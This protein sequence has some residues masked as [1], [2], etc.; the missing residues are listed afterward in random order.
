MRVAVVHDWLVTYAGAERV[1]EQILAL[2]PEADVFTLVDFLP[3]DRRQ[4][5]DGRKVV[6][7]FIQRLPRAR[8]AYRSYL[9][10]F[11]LAVEQFDLS[12]YDVV[13]SSSHAAAKGIIARP[14][15]T[16]ICYCHT[17]ARYAWDLQ[18]HYLNDARLGKGIKGALVRIVLHYFRLWDVAASS[19][20][21]YF[22]ANSHYVARRLA[23][24]YRRDAAVIYPPVD[25]ERFTPA[26]AK[27]DYYLTVSRFVPYKKIDLIVDAFRAMPDRKL[28]IVGDGPERAK[29]FAKAAGA[30]N[31]SILGYRSDSEVIELMRGARAFV[32]CA[33]EDF[34]IV[35]VEAQACGTPVVAYGKGGAAETVVDGVTGVLYDAQVP[36]A[37]VDAIM[38]AEKIRFDTR[39]IRNKAERFSAARFRKEFSDFVRSV[40]NTR[41]PVA[42]N[43]SDDALDLQRK[44]S[45]P[46]G[47]EALPISTC[48]SSS[49]LPDRQST[50]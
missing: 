48:T 43:A 27:R 19:R 22:V 42:S 21:D 10:L 35:L 15:Q 7:S 23:K 46:Y 41:F 11:P 36:E 31:I 17:P 39:T 12:S 13:I 2:F 44:S 28:V 3:S 40:T 16:H 1:L 37:I 26:D 32:Y 29:I 20:V 47:M 9:P 49:K 8:N 45:T 18:D 6:T 4:F 50:D 14:D 34:G 5:L 38:R 25:V 33:E 24:T 30:S